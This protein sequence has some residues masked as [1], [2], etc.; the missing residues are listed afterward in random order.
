MFIPNNF[1]ILI[2]KIADNKYGEP[3]FSSGTNVPCGVVEIKAD[4][5]K[6]AIRTD[7]SAS[8]GN[9]DEIVSIAMI[10]FPAYVN[11]AVGDKFFIAN[12]DLRVMMVE[13]RYSISGRLDH[14]QCQFEAWAT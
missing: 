4:L 11:I 1:G 7:S 2:K 5:K 14:H 10:L 13:P 3:I 6:T 9:A 12:V 8:R